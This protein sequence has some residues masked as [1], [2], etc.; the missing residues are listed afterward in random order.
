MVE[1]ALSR[2]CSILEMKLICDYLASQVAQL[3]K[4]LPA[5]TGDIRDADSDPGLGRSPGVGNSTRLQ[6]SF[7]ENSV[8]RGA[9]WARVHGVTK[10]QT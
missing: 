3:V 10:S 9:W 8:D 2:H 1:A 5:N 4:N 6:Y 7:L